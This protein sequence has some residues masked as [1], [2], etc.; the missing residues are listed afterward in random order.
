MNILVVGCGQIGSQIVNTLAKDH[1][2]TVLDKSPPSNLLHYFRGKR[3]I[4]LIKLDITNREAVNTVIKN[5]QPKMVI[6]TTG[7]N[8]ETVDRDRSL[9]QRHLYDEPTQFIKNISK[10]TIERLIYMSSFSV[11]G[12]YATENGLTEC[13]E[14]T[15]VNP[16]TPYGEIKYKCEQYLVNE[17][18]KD[19]LI[20][21][22]TGIF[23]QSNPEGGSYGT[24]MID[25][26]F[27][28]LLNGHYFEIDYYGLE[29][30]MYNKTLAKLL[31]DLSLNEQ[32]S[33][34]IINMSLFNR[35]GCKPLRHFFASLLNNPS[36]KLKTKDKPSVDW[37]LINN[38]KMLSLLTGEYA[39]SLLNDFKDYYHHAF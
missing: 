23:G 30:V 11:Y 25:Q 5:T 38:D 19:Y 8:A 36:I 39:F 9:G 32:V 33:H 37:P 24:K 22:P 28:S 27:H 31:C 21:R 6:L 26:L 1:Q 34:K 16:T 20:L 7:I 14:L 18:K 15:P 17:W 35:M 13:N 29:D 2:V 3:S 10:T 12:M 4:N